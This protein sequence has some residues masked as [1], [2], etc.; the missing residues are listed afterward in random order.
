MVEQVGVGRLVS[1]ANL[2][3]SGARA[4]LRRVS[5]LE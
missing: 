5:V 2:P 1:A 3:K 4:A